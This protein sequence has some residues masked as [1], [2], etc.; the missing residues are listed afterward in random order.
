M[1]I[2]RG[3]F[4]VEPQ[5]PSRNGQAVTERT[6]LGALHRRY[7]FTS[8]GARRYAVAEHVG[9][10]PLGPSRVADFMVM[11][12]WKSTGFEVA[13]HE[14]KISRGDWLRELKSPDKAGE[15][16]PYVNR[17]WV[18]VPSLV[19]VVMGELPAEWGLMAL[20]GSGELR[21]AREA[22]RRDAL[23]MPADRLAAFLRAVQKTAAAQ[24]VRE[25]GQ[26]PL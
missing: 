1:T 4:E 14:V 7:C 12:L 24:A 21:A 20:T 16:A 6:M 18:V 19:I 5:P 17:W 11:D 2:Q 9:N 22:P 13:G 26:E 3:I 10:R 25:L 8:A 15:F 23:P